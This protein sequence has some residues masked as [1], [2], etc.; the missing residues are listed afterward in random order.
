MVFT[1]TR[2]AWFNSPPV[3]HRWQSALCDVKK[4]CPW[5]THFMFNL[6]LQVSTDAIKRMNH[7]LRSVKA[8]PA[9]ISWRDKSDR[10]ALNIHPQLRRVLSLTLAPRNKSFTVWI[11]TVPSEAEPLEIIYKKRLEIYVP[12]SKGQ[13]LRRFTTTIYRSAAVFCMSV[14]IQILASDSEIKSTAGEW[15][16]V[17]KAALNTAQSMPSAK[18]RSQVPSEWACLIFCHAVQ[19]FRGP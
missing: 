12:L 19:F 2:F 8:V 4:K 1:W 3:R 9:S 6:T 13:G 5:F 17:E 16:F 14:W 7:H 11:A 10:I 18:K 15:S